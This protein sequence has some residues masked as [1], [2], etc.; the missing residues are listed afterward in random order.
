MNASHGSTITTDVRTALVRHGW[1]LPAPWQLPPGTTIPATLVRI[2]GQRVLVSGHVPLDVDGTICGPFGRVGAD[3]DVPEA[4]RAGIRCLLAVLASLDHTLG[5]LGRI[6][7]WCRLHC[8]AQLAD[9]VLDVPTIFNPAS[10]LLLDLFGET[11]GAHAR[12]A[13]GVS[14]LPWNAPVEIEA[15]LEI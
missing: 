4:Q 5:D 2:V 10:Q 9:A 1:T 15:E 12:I 14:R 3:L 6:T 7:A 13:I 8:M 11:S